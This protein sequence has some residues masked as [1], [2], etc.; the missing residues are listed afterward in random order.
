MERHYY[1]AESLGDEL[2]AFEERYGL[3]SAEFYKRH[4][5]GDDPES[6]TPFDRVVWSDTF[7]EACRLADHALQP[8]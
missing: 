4:V 7:R 2:R 6:V 3:P 8:A 5:H 1:S